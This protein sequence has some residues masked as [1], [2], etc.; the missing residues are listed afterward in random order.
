MLQARTAARPSPSRCAAAPAPAA[1]ATSADAAWPE[2]LPA[3]PLTL[4]P[5]LLRGPFALQAAK[6]SAKD[7]DD[8][9]LEFL[10]KKKVRAG[11]CRGGSCM[12]SQL[13]HS[14]GA[15]S[16]STSLVLRGLKRERGAS[17]AAAQEEEA[18]LKKA[19]EAALKG[20]KK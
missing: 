10:K 17:A 8:T 20:K 15:A 16:I 19:K 13:V 3:A 1:A 9:D 18:A 6:K 4:P 11:S 2:L 14:T 5:L 7:Y 12:R